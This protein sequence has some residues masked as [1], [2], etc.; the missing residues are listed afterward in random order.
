MINVRDIVDDAF[1]AVGAIQDG[2][3][4]DGDLAKVGERHLNQ[5]VASLNLNNF[6]AFQRTTMDFRVPSAKA[7]FLIGPEQPEGEVQPDIV[8]QRPASVTSVYVGECALNRLSEVIMVAQAKMPM[9]AS[10]SA[11]GCPRCVCYVSSYPLG[12]LWFDMNIP[13]G[14]T[15]RLCYSKALPEMKID[16]VLE[17]PA[18]YQGALTWELAK[19]LTARYQVS[20]KA[21][22]SIKEKAEF[23]VNA[24]R[25]NTSVK[26]PVQAFAGYG[27]P[28]NILNWD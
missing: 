4:S 26:T 27:R 23:F 9:F 21:M 10:G 3:H 12:D 6:F 22:A 17:V 24:I 5:L 2:E 1:A 16:D 14:W 8:A 13:A 18:E 15:I 25:S 19:L 11:T 7:H 28:R 20:D